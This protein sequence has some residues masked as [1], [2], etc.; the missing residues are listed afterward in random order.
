VSA[1]EQP[2]DI[3]NQ[4]LSIGTHYLGIGGDASLVHS[5]HWKWDGTIQ[6]TITYESS[7]LPDVAI[8]STTAGDWIDE[9]DITDTSITGV[10]GGA[11]IHIGNCGAR[12]LRAKVVV[13]VAGRLR[14]CQ[15]GK[16]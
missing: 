9:A 11:M 6:A 12:R 8:T 1:I 5:V 4:S 15:H 14:G 3:V 10:A 2:S 7:N 13:T 16:A